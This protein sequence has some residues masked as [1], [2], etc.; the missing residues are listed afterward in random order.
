MEGIM[1][2]N[3][4]IGII[5]GLVGGYF[6][7]GG[8]STEKGQISVVQAFIA[9]ITTAFLTAAFLWSGWAGI[10]AIIELVVGYII[11]KKLAS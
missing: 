5:I 11:A 7:R 8:I 4:I 1:I 9:I 6:T 10:L 3:I 2:L